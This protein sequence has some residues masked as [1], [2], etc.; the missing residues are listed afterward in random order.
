KTSAAVADERPSRPEARKL[1]KHELPFR[2]EME[3]NPDI[4][5]TLAP[6]LEGKVALGF[7]AETDDMETSG[8]RKMADKGL[9]LLF[10][11][12]VGEG[13]GFGAAS[14]E[15]ILLRDD[16]TRREVE[17]M[18]KEDLADLLLDEVAARLG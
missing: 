15:G 10:A 9:A 16:G 12:P 4:L 18:P 2:I 14:G 13:K 5:M 7:A 8:R 11:N 1:H 17:P 6:A 3:P